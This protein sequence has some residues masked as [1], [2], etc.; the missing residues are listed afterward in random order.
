[1]CRCLTRDP[2]ICTGEKRL[3]KSRRH[4]PCF[5]LLQVSQSLLERPPGNADPSAQPKVPPPPKTHGVAVAT[6]EKSTT[7]PLFPRVSQAKM[8]VRYPALLLQR[9][10]RRGLCL[11]GPKPLEEAL[12]ALCMARKGLSGWYTLVWRLLISALEDVG[13][14]AETQANNSASGTEDCQCISIS[15]PSLL[16]IALVAHVD[17]EFAPPDPLARKLNHRRSLSSRSTTRAVCGHGGV[18]PLQGETRHDYGMGK[19]PRARAYA[20]ACATHCVRLSCRCRERGGTRL[21]GVTL[22]F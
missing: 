12:D 18:S 20:R 5:L 13:P 22:D 16:G 7:E 21:I 4:L 3:E 17:P 15:I 11:G 14:Y 8:R 19:G 9:C 10:V 6:D 1:M 2:Q